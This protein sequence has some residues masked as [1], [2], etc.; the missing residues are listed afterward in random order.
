MDMGIIFDFTKDDIKLSSNIVI[1]MYMEIQ[2]IVGV[3]N[4]IFYY[5]YFIV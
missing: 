4:Y 5:Y 1:V 2:F 3:I